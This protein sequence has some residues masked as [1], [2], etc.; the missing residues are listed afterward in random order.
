MTK[1]Q[2]I[3][4]F[5]VYIYRKCVKDQVAFWNVIKCDVHRYNMHS[6]IL[7]CYKDLGSIMWVELSWSLKNDFQQPVY[8][9]KTCQ[10]P[11][12][13]TSYNSNFHWIFF[14]NNAWQKINPSV[15]C[16][17]SSNFKGNYLQSAKKMHLEFILLTQVEIHLDY[18]HIEKSTLEIKTNYEEATFFALVF[19]LWE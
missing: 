12:I 6:N 18:Y 8:T 9:Q 16:A 19:H 17:S 11:S 4:I 13:S 7:S 5:Y 1:F 15:S 14:Q 3:N 10:S 2:E